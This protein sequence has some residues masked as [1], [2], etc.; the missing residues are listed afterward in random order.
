MPKSLNVHD[1]NHAQGRSSISETIVSE[2][3]EKSS[4]MG[5]CNWLFEDW[6]N[7]TKEGFSFSLIASQLCIP[8]MSSR[9]CEGRRESV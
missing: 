2:T 4:C 3:I 8:G 7:L 9:V 1:A 6:F 5:S